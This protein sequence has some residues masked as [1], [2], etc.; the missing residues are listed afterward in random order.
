M[1]F[2]VV[3]IYDFI[4]LRFQNKIYQMFASL[5]KFVGEGLW[6]KFMTVHKLFSY[7]KLLQ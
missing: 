3:Q 1:I 4:S 2:L 7:L 6:V 5:E